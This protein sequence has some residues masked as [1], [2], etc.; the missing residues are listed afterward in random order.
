M[1]LTAASDCDDVGVADLAL[2]PRMSL[3][4]VVA[5]VIAAIA[6]LAP[7]AAPGGRF[8]PADAHAPGS[9]EELVVLLLAEGG[10]ERSAL[11]R[12]GASILAEY[13]SFV[14]AGLAPEVLRSIDADRVIELPGR[15]TFRF[16]AHT[17]DLSAPDPESVLPDALRV[18]A[19]PGAKEHYVVKFIGPVKEE[20]VRGVEIAGGSV[21]RPVDPTSFL[22]RMDSESLARV[23]GLPGVMWTGLYQ[24]A[25]KLAPGL[26]GAGDQLQ[27]SVYTFP[28][29]RARVSA[30]L[31]RSTRADG[32]GA[33]RAE[34]FSG[35]PVSPHLGNGG[36]GLV[37]AELDP[38]QLVAAARHP[39]VLFIEPFPPKL[40]FNDIA[41]SILQTGTTTA[42]GAPASFA[43]GCC[44]DTNVKV[45]NK[46]L[47]GQGT[48]AGVADT[49]IRMDHNQF[50]NVSG[51][52]APGPSHRKVVRYATFP[53]TGN[54]NTYR[55]LCSDHGTHVSATIAGYDNPVGGTSNNDGGAPGARISFGDIDLESNCAASDTLEVPADYRDMWLPAVADGARSHSN[56]WGSGY[57]AYYSGDMF[58]IDEF[59][60]E[61]ELML[62]TWAAGNAGPGLNTVG[63]QAEAKN[64]IT[65]GAQGRTIPASEIQLGDVASFSSRGP[66]WDG[67]RKPD[68]MAPGVAIN[69]A[70]SAGTSGDVSFQGT[71]MATPGAQAAVAIMSQYFLEGWYPSGAKVPA[72]AFNASHSLV[73]ALLINGAN[74][75]NGG[76][77]NS[78]GQGFYPNDNQGWGRIHLDNSLY[79]AGDAVKMQ[80]FDGD[81]GVLTGEHK[82]FKYRV[83]DTS[84][85]LRVTVN[86]ND[87]PAT[88][89]AATALVNNLDLLVTAPDGDTFKGN[90]FTGWNPA[91][92]SKNTGG[93][94]A[95]NNV[96]GFRLPAG[97]ADLITGVWTVRVTGTNVPVAPQQFAFAI[98]GGIDLDYGTVQLD[99][100]LYSE[101]QTAQVRVE[102]SGATSPV[103]VNASSALTGDYEVVSLPGG[104]GVF[105][106]PLD[107][108]LSAAVPNDGFLSVKN[109][110][111]V[112]ASYDDPTGTAHV[113]TDTA[114]IDAAGPAISNVR[115]TLITEAAATVR[116]DTGEPAASR[117]SYGP[118]PA[119]G[120]TTP[121]SSPLR[122]AQTADVS[123]LAASTLYYY[124]VEAKDMFGHAV[125][126]D[127]GGAHYTFTAGAV[128]ELLLVDAGDDSVEFLPYYDDAFGARGWSFNHWHVRRDGVPPL[129]KLQQYKAVIWK[130][131]ERYPQSTPAE[132]ALI[133]SYNDGGG[134]LWFD[135]Q[136]IAWDTCQSGTGCPG[137]DPDPEWL[138]SQLKAIYQVDPAVVTGVVGVASDPISGS[139]TGGLAYNRLRDGGSGDE[140]DSVAAGGTP[141][142]VW[143]DSGPDASPDDI[144]VKWVSAANNGTAGT[145][146]WGGTPS[147]VAA[148]FFESWR[149]NWVDGVYADAA[150][151][152]IVDKTLL[153][154]V[155]HDHPDVAITA[156]AGG[157]SFTA[158]PVT[159]SW[160]R[161]THGGTSVASQTIHYSP[162]GGQTWV[163]LADPA[164]GDTSYLWDVTGLLNGNGY[165]VRV[166][167][168]DSGAP[169]PPA[170]NGSANSGTFEIALPGGDF[171]GPVVQAGSIA[172][173]S[174]PATTPSGFSITATIDDSGKGNSNVDAASPA[175][176]SIVPAGA[177]PS[178]WTG[179]NLSSAPTSPTEGVTTTRPST[180]LAP[181]S[182]DV[183]VRGRDAAGNLGPPAKLSTT[184]EVNAPI[185]EV[186][187]G[188]MLAASVL[189]TGAAMLWSLRPG[190]LGGPRRARTARSGSTGPVPRREK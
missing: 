68:V 37:E 151:T 160:T 108:T 10:E 186:A 48:V 73:K 15:E 113:A 174:N 19:N 95:V 54:D 140:I 55:M 94:D 121:W 47:F 142:Y 72:N 96:E 190:L 161:T 157:S 100:D 158:T 127:N 13:P 178:T 184:L 81:N 12:A 20:W 125:L 30:F 65:I 169:S 35:G 69:S 17:L 173:S 59:A 129:A 131:V 53:S 103:A 99:R 46:G 170:L 89:G 187:S 152:E 39:G 118:T 62:F 70:N 16:G 33:V 165:K 130:P 185:P 88:V 86:W 171:L 64:A 154:L 66:T 122:T 149:I 85:P 60:Y 117:V 82:E 176:Y 164:P 111:T 71:S 143:R 102:D 25:Y 74:E 155:G 146:V 104:S 148:F 11:V 32:R 90:V 101:A 84:V 105:S 58:A 163:W 4:A 115:A 159:I 49:G 168:R 34:H 44:G 181:G 156:P 107:F 28:E 128:G 189:A 137:T 123:G 63:N 31:E 67:R 116:F 109:A 114:E 76:G 162:D 8:S 180:G 98:T 56:S 3:A 40:P 167:V 61:N 7:G 126:D 141:S 91:F 27:V 83:T 22:V 172:V 23:R 92:S 153:W 57:V 51:S 145:G 77:S 2:A 50:K 182:Y 124:D 132:R 9:G 80:V 14:L 29:D 97:N 41:H 166:E 110:D 21:F 38:S 75:M 144:A 179:M 78:N 150:R 5:A 45:W 24:P 52:N 147:K 177:P 138:G 120:T 42:V 6:P 79:F 133:K 136:D 139:Y 119:L 93:Y 43:A 188:A 36:I 183:W 106:G 175:D 26:L 18:S 134:R 112:T 87:Y 1:S 135:S